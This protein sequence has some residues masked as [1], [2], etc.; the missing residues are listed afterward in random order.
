MARYVI[1]LDYGTDKV[2]ALVACAETGECLASCERY[3][4]RWKRGIYCN[5]ALNQWRQHPCDYLEVL[6]QSVCEV[7]SQCPVG[8]S[9][10]VVGI[11]LDTT[12]STPVF[13]DET[14]TPLAMLP[15]FSD[16]PNAM[17]ILW[18]DHT[19][20]SEAEEI[21][22][23][24]K[25][26][27][28]DYTKYEG[29]IYSAEW[30]WAKV[31]HVLREDDSV[32]SKA[33]SIVECCEW[34]PA[35]LTG[36]RSSMGIVRSRCACGH[37]AMWHSEWGGF[38]PE[39]FLVALE[40]KLAGFRSHSSLNTETADVPVGTLCP[41][42]AKR[43]GLSTNVV[44]AGGAYNCHFG[45]VGAGVKPN[46]LVRVIDSSTCDVMVASYDEI[47]ER[48]IKGICGQVDGSVIPGMV[49]LEA[50]QSSFGDVYS[51][52]CDL[53][54]YPL[55]TVL[56]RVL[57]E[58]MSMKDIEAVQ[59]KVS[60]HMLQAISRDAARIPISE[61]TIIA[62]DWV[63]GRRTPDANQNLQATV[64]GLTL[65]TAAPH[66][67]RALVEATAFGTKS[68]V[69]R[70]EDEGLRINEV[71]G[72]G[73]IALN[74]PFIMQTMCDVINKPIKVCNTDNACAL[75][76]TMFAATAAGVYE[77]VEDA[78]NSMNSG[79]AKEYHPI[80][81]NAE[82]YSTLYDKYKTLGDVTES[83]FF[84]NKNA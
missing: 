20:I 55:Y 54:K 43:L 80:P 17:F 44:V 42:W 16:N 51:M 68:I 9:S 82:I 28:T 47:G 75:G 2:R 77:T 15:E 72:I 57:G 5:L 18:K 25:Q 79:F 74:S 7:L 58:K 56:P 84:N 52:F 50:G 60:E 65:G 46:T 76:A 66:F 21:T 41:E 38:P 73:D 81:A 64:C 8:V 67:F 35:V 22:K 49:G 14:G 23:L 36:V 24:C 37:K 10:N 33:Y 69:E 40:P 1:G 70:F 11:A 4:P 63:N 26:W 30:F 31:V 71:L 12:G 19:A 27:Q 48:C 34:L 78:I 62:T 32:A 59:E 13:T 83:L 53:L 6:E 45:A 61:S 3:Y 39:D 29:G